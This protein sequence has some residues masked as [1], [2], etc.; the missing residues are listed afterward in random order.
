M[1]FSAP[2]TSFSAR[3]ETAF[4]VD[5]D[6]SSLGETASATENEV[7]VNKQDEA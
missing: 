5:V 3:K 1:Q 6:D 7:F 4:R 2:E